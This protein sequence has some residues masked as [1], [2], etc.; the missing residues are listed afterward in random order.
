M[1]SLQAK[2]GL[3]LING[4]QFI[5]ALGAMAIYRAR[6]IAESAD[7]IAALSVEAL[8]G[9]SSAATVFFER[10]GPKGYPLRRDGL[11]FY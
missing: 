3:A 5:T 8:R 11:L 1:C 10:R 9:M 6:I 4:T 2:E 7:Y